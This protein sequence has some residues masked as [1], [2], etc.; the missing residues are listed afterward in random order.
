MKVLFLQP[1]PPHRAGDIAEVAIGHAQNFLFPKGLAR[2]ATAEAVEAAK[3]QAVHDAARNV[4]A[5]QKLAGVLQA[6][7]GKTIVI[8]ARTAP[9][10]T[11]YAALAP[12]AIAAGIQSAIGVALPAEFYPQLPTLKHTGEQ[13]VTLQ[14]GGQTATFTLKV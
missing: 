6:L 12:K 13:E 5:S 2:L 9:T 1:V 3:K 11:L 7:A 14:H 4:E 10:G 8:P